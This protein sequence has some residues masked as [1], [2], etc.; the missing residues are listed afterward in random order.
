MP[1]IHPVTLEG[2][3][4]YQ[5]GVEK[6]FSI[7]MRQPGRVLMRKQLDKDYQLT[8]I[9][10]ELKSGK[11]ITSLIPAVIRV[12]QKDLESDAVYLI[13]PSAPQSTYVSGT[14][15]DAIHDDSLNQY[16]LT[17]ALDITSRETTREIVVDAFVPPT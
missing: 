16:S 1:V 10:F 9:D 4:L 5:P 2:S 13:I 7:G 14:G 11:F 6:P 15:D 3:T 12:Y 8:Q 17:T